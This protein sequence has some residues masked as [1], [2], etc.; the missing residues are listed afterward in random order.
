MTHLIYIYKLI[1]ATAARFDS[2]LL[3]AQVSVP[4]VLER[5]LRAVGSNKA[6]AA[7]TPL[8][9]ARAFS[10]TIV[11]ADKHRYLHN[12]CI[13]ADLYKDPLWQVFLAS[14]FRARVR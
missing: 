8:P 12:I 7:P 14:E 1:Y 10:E 2:N 6:S 9:R 5:P 3:R 4:I 11:M 13:D